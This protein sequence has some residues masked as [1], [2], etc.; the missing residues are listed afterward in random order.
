MNV[1][2]DLVVELQDENLLEKTVIDLEMRRDS[3]PDSFDN[4]RVPETVTHLAEP[5]PPEFEYG[6]VTGDHAAEADA[7]I[8]CPRETE[9]EVDD[10]ST[11]SGDPAAPAE[12]EPVVQA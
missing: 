10:F 4:A 12:N 7:P 2:E 1:F 3:V 8:E 6:I 9:V 5:K 11:P